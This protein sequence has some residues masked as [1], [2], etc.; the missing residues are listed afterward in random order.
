[1]AACALPAC[2]GARGA[3]AADGKEEV[4]F[5]DDVSACLFLL[6]LVIWHQ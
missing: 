3:A 5:I 4:V 1:M 6:H 2:T